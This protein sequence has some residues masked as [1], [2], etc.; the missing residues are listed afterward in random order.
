MPGGKLEAD[1]PAKG[2][3][4]EKPPAKGNADAAGAP[5]GGKTWTAPET[6]SF[7][8]LNFKAGDRLWLWPKE[9]AVLKAVTLGPGDTIS[10]PAYRLNIRRVSAASFSV[11][12]YQLR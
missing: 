11:R 9:D 5:A 4:L 12:S 1:R 8:Q 10:G 2:R 6:V 3:D 7:G